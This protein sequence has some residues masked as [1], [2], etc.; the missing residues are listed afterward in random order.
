MPKSSYPEVK[1][2]YTLFKGGGVIMKTGTWILSFCIM[3]I[4]TW[5][6]YII[7]I[8]SWKGKGR[9]GWKNAGILFCT[10]SVLPLHIPDKP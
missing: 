6:A 7:L 10:L 4:E 5:G 2:Q 8:P 3:A 9:D 1:R